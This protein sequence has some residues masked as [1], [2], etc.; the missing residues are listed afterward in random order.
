MMDNKRLIPYHVF[1]VFDEYFIFDT[2]NCRLNRIDSLVFEC[3]M[4]SSSFELNA[5]KKNVIDNKLV[6]SEDEMEKLFAELDVIALTS[7]S[8]S[9]HFAE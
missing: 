5:I 1:C 2:T 7:C 9:H 3:L 8:P 4:L 6:N